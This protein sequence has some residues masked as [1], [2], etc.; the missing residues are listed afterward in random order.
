VHPLRNRRPRQGK[1]ASEEATDTLRTIEADRADLPVYRQGLARARDPVYREDLPRTNGRLSAA[2]VLTMEVPNME[3]VRLKGRGLFKGRDHPRTEDLLRV[4]D[5]PRVDGQV[6]AEDPPRVEDLLRGED[7]DQAG[8]P[9]PV[10]GAVLREDPLRAEDLAD[11]GDPPPEEDREEL[12]AARPSKVRSI[13]A[14]NKL[15]RNSSNQR[16]SRITMTSVRKSRRRNF[17]SS[18][19]RSNSS[20]KQTL[21]PER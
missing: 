1:E 3:D 6:P 17:R 13:R 2:G 11:R 12:R 4:E 15:R 14:R 18:A 20:T 5:P 8:D 21:S 7:P 19:S 9:L 16:R 10:E